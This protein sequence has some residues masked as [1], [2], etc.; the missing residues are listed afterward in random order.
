[1]SLAQAKLQRRYRQITIGFIVLVGL[2][3]GGVVYA[4]WSTT[5]IEIVPI[6]S[7][8]TASLTVTVSP[9][10]EGPNGIVGTAT[11][12]EESSSQTVEPT[13]EGAKQAAHARGMVTL[14]NETAGSQALATGTR[15]ESS[16][17]IIV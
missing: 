6:Q 15:L 1:M 5:T 12:S 9:S 2:V 11:V 17:G 7:N 3:L 16:E 4:G 13:G 14:H 8:L 10:G